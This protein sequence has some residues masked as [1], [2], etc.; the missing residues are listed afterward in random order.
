MAQEGNVD[1]NG[2]VFREGRDGE[3]QRKKYETLMN[4]QIVSTRY[5]DDSCLCALGLFDSV[6]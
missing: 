5:T 6:R 3:K 2:I 4:E 1:Y